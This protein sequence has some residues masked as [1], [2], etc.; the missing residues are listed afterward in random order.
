MKKIILIFLDELNK[1]VSLLRKFMGEFGRLK[2]S[3]IVNLYTKP[4]CSNYNINSV[5]M[6]AIAYWKLPGFIVDF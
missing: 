1:N 2:K 6:S 5:Y 3:S 4:N